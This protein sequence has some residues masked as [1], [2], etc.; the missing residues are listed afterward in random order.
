MHSGEPVAREWG[1]G[2]ATTPGGGQVAGVHDRGDGQDQQATAAG[3]RA[4]GQWSITAA[5][6]QRAAAGLQR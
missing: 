5:M 2:A 6:G 3:Q 4:V 1:S